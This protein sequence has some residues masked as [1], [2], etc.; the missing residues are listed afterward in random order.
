MGGENRG[1]MLGVAG[2]NR[3]HYM[4]ELSKRIDEFL[5]PAG[6]ELADG[7]HQLVISRNFAGQAFGGAVAEDQIV[8]VADEV[9]C[10]RGPLR[11]AV[12]VEALHEGE[13]STADFME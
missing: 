7:L 11:A 6:D 10:G 13:H 5:L 9:D 12:A 3:V 1:G 4:H 8:Q 2:K